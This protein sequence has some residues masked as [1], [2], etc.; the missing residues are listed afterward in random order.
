MTLTYWM[1]NFYGYTL[2]ITGRLDILRMNLNYEAK[3]AVVSKLWKDNNMGGTQVVNTLDILL[4]IYEDLKETWSETLESHVFLRPVRGSTD[5]IL[6]RLRNRQAMLDAP[7]IQILTM[8][9]RKP[10]NLMAKGKMTVLGDS[11]LTMHLTTGKHTAEDRKFSR[12][13]AKHGLEMKFLEDRSN[14]GAEVR[15]RLQ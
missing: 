9:L 3:S 12:Q 15:S 8:L 2:N 1:D 7:F 4:S 10:I 5:Y 11:G 13:A 6:S 14:N